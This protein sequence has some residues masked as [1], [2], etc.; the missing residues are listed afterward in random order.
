MQCHSIR[1][2]L[3]KST[4]RIING[5]GVHEALLTFPVINLPNKYIQPTRNSAR[6]IAQ[7]QRSVV[8]G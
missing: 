8:V 5:S 1:M 2:K 6:I 7:M 4:L 3:Q